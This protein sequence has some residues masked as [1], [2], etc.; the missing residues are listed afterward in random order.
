MLRLTLSWAGQ[1]RRWPFPEAP[2][3]LGSSS[4]CELFAA[5]R[6][7]SRVHAEVRPSSD[8]RLRLRDL[9]STNGVLQDGVRQ[10]DVTLR[11]GE[12]VQLGEGLLTLEEVPSGDDVAALGWELESKAENNGDGGREETSPFGDSS[13]ADLAAAAGAGPAA[14]LHAMRAIESHGG[15]TVADEDAPLRRRARQA[16]GAEV[17]LLAARSKEGG[18]VVLACDGALSGEGSWPELLRGIDEEASGSEATGTP[19]RLRLT[20]RWVLLQ[21]NDNDLLAAVFPPPAAPALWQ[22][23]FFAYLAGKLLNQGRGKKRVVLRDVAPRPEERRVPEEMVLGESPAIRGLLRHLEAISGSDLPVLLLGET[24]VGKEL[25]ARLVHDWSHSAAGPFVAINCAAIPAELLE[26]ELFGVVRGA[27]TGVEPR[28][29]L[30]TRAQGGS[31]FLDE[32]GAMPEPLQ[33]KV[34]RVLQEREVLPVG[35][36]VI[37]KVDARVIAASNRDLFELTRERRFRSDLY[38]RLRGVELHVP[39]LRE[40]REEI[41]ALVLAFARRAAERHGKEIVGVSRRALELLEGHDWPGNVRELGNEIER[42]VLVCPSGSLL[43]S[44]SFGAVLWHRQHGATGERRFERWHGALGDPAGG[45]SDDAG[46]QRPFEPGSS[47]S[48]SPSRTPASPPRPLGPGSENLSLRDHVDELERRVILQALEENRGNKAA[49]ARR[50]GI[51][52][53]GLALKMKRLGLT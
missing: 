18:L 6:G 11:P 24:G 34:L 21:G 37:Q 44:Q 19:P 5:C 20:G 48:G 46:G 22:Q 2:V 51:T 15:L 14:A 53:N 49:T 29:G 16:L 36:T 33:A 38:Y 39:P 52:R 23:D 17:L 25:F 8:D 30:F 35:A 9:G 45:L 10:D 50:L 32:I 47:Q 41:P 26:A 3:R 42:A 28:P 12:S 40:R 27:A 31:L 7:I 4:E 13:P 1:V 43:D